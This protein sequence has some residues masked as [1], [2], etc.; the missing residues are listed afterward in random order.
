M[1]LKKK[2]D[3]QVD[4]SVLLRRRNK[5]IKRSRRFEGLGRKRS[6]EGEK[7]R[8]NQVWE[9]MEEIYRG[10]GNCTDV[11]SNGEWGTV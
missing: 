9:E 1:K 4:A 2:K 10:S 8:K 3:Q 7:E 5:I 11:C 6:G